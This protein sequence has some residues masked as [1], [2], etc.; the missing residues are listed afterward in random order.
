MRGVMIL[1]CNIHVLEYITLYDPVLGTLVIDTKAYSSSYGEK[2]SMV[3]HGGI[4]GM[5]PIFHGYR[6]ETIFDELTL[7]VWGCIPTRGFPAASP[8]LW[9][10]S[11][12]RPA[13]AAPLTAAV[14][15]WTR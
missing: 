14:S 7:S 1:R 13:R 9:V 6:K 12:R 15:L 3:R 8:R 5:A 11:H 2:R 10:D 4:S